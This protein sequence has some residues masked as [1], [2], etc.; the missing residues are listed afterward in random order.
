MNKPLMKISRIP[1]ALK[2]SAVQLCPTLSY[3]H[4]KAIVAL[5]YLKG[6]NKKDEGRVFGR[7]RSDRT[8]GNGF[9]VKE[10]RVRLDIRKKSFPGRVGKP[11]HRLPRE[12]M[13]APSLEVSKAKLGGAWS[14]LG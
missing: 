2:G 13:A 3:P 9:K 4:R 1:A 6:A 5:Q 10:S 14:N 12:A 7:A 8:R 11:W